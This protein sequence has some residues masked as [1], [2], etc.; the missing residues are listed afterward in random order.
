MMFSSYFKTDML[1]KFETKSSRVK[2]L[3][4]HPKRQWVLASLHNG[5]IQ[6][7]DYQEKTLID[8][9]DGHQGPVRGL[10]FHKSQQL[11]VSGG[12][13]A[14]IKLWNYQTRKCIF[15]LD[16]HEDYIRTTFFHREYPWILSASDDQSIRIWNWQSR[17][18]IAVL[19]GHTH[20]V[21]CAQF[22]PSKDLILSAS[23]DQTLRLWDITPLKSKN[24]STIP[25]KDD[26]NAGLPE[27]LTKTDYAVESKD[28]HLSEINWCSFHPKK[29]LCLSTADDNYIK[30]WRVDRFGLNELYT[31]RG[32]YNNVNCAIFHPKKD[33]ILSASEDRSIRVWDMDKRTPL[34][35]HR[36]D[37]DRFW[38]VVAHPNE[39]LFAAGHDTGLMVFKTERE[40]PVYIV[41]KDEIVLIKN[42]QEARYNMKTGDFAFSSDTKKAP[43]LASLIGNSKIDRRVI[44]SEN[45]NL[46]ARIASNQITISDGQQNVLCT[47]REQ[48]KIKS[49]IWDVSGVLVYS[50]PVHIKYALVDGHCAT[51]YSPQEIFYIVAIRDRYLYC[52]DRNCDIKQV[53]FDPREFKFK[54]AVIKNDR[55][56]ILATIKQLGKLSRA[57]I[58]FLVKKGYPG[59]ALKFVDDANTRFP[60][61]LQAFDIDDALE[62]AIKINNK[63]C[64]EQL[65]EVAMQVGH[66]KAAERAYK[67]LKKPYKLSMLYLVCGQKTKMSEARSL[68]KELSDTSTEFVISLLMK[69][70]VECTQIIRR[71]GH[72]NLAYACAVNHGLY[73]LALEISQELSDDQLS[74]LPPLE[75]ALTH[76]SWMQDVI[77]EI[78]DLKFENWPL[79]NDEQESFDAVLN[80]EPD[81]DVGSEKGDWND[82]DKASP[83]EVLE[84]LED[85]QDGWVE[86]EMSDEDELEEEKEEKS[87]YTAPTPGLSITSNWS[88]MSDLAL[89]HVLTGS[90]KSAFRLLEDQVGAINPEPLKKIFEDLFLQSRAAYQGLALYST[91]YIYP[92][93]TKNKGDIVTLPSGGYQI[94][95]LEKRLTDS[96]SLFSKGRFREAIES[97][98]SLLLSTLF[99][100]VY[101]RESTLSVDEQIDRVKE[102]IEISKEYILGLQIWLARK[103]ITGKE[104]E[105]QKRVCELTV[106][107]S[108]LNMAKHKGR[109]LEEALKVF[110][111]RPKDLQKTQAAASVARRFLGHPSSS[112]PSKSKMVAE[113]EKIKSSYDIQVDQRVGLDFEDQNPYFLCATSYKPIKKNVLVASCP[114][115]DAKYKPEFTG[116]TCNICT[117][118]EIGRQTTG[119]KFEVTGF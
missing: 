46:V 11:F 107:F 26:M 119:I 83:D 75:K 72:P 50:T 106:Y 13:D 59:L 34:S 32:H 116:K 54:Q 61:A 17:S 12:D 22:H 6:L 78:K 109:V 16:A 1:V 41:I 14:K 24:T 43:T 69:D 92:T 71:C 20:Y 45:R 65:A 108:K 36:K 33:L 31:L 19:T 66:V 98:R 58:S 29:D 118:S 114:L 48:R 10:D 55:A 53:E 87:E 52:I 117:L 62:S 25:S 93:S 60:L 110:L 35:T 73:E 74:R 67:E 38:V 96:Y 101:P 64:W 39:N 79:L 77:P 111:K 8:K 21:M 37:V 44:T 40:R 47:I 84:D 9:F 23:I 104:L 95:E 113:A 89:H 7:W 85:A 15:T 49:A 91:L 18:R 3:S 42:N 103:E 70:F 112:D 86:E 30:V 4:F 68:A 57:E 80:E 2:G 90:Y 27:I 115:C 82:D 81:I 88:R 51:L 63:L 105:D 5:T 102:M 94:E 56:G 28:A 100:Q 97:F 99:L 76:K